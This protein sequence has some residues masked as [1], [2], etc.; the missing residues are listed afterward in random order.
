[1]RGSPF[2]IAAPAAFMIAS[3]VGAT[4]SPLTCICMWVGG[5]TGVGEWVWHVL[6]SHLRWPGSRRVRPGS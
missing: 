4:S 3:L 6:A 1:M 5:W 2:F